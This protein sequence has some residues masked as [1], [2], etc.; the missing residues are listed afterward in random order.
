MTVQIAVLSDIHAN[1]EALTTALKLAEEHKADSV[2]CLGDVVGYGPDP[3]ACIELIQTT[4]E[5]CVLGNHD[6]AVAFD[7]NLYVLPNDAQTVVRRHQRTLSENHL[8]WL[9]ALPLRYDAHGASF[10]HSTPE[11]PAAWNRL[12]SFHAVQA[13]FSFFD[14]PICFVGHSHKPAVASNTVGVLRVRPGHRF[15]VDV[16]SVGQPRDKDSRLGFALFDT[17]EFACVF[18][19]AHYDVERTAMRIK[20]EGFP[21]V[22]AERLKQGW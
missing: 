7:K 17:K 3:A 9:R 6:E 15:L 16:G 1:L 8:E 2:I 21:S 12:E 14:G 18:V 22:L 5:A 10:V 4:C 20:E 11:D 19:R 13:Q